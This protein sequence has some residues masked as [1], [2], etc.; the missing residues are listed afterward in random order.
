STSSPRMR[1]F[2]TRAQVSQSKSSGLLLRAG[3][4]EGF[5]GSG[6]EATASAFRAA[7]STAYASRTRASSSFRLATCLSA[8]AR[9]SSVVRLKVGLAD[10]AAGGRVDPTLSI[11]PPPLSRCVRRLTYRHVHKLAPRSSRGKNRIY[12]MN[13]AT[14]PDLSRNMRGL[15]DEDGRSKR[16]RPPRETVTP[17]DLMVYFM[18]GVRPRCPW[19]F[20]G[21]WSSP[22]GSRSGR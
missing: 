16:W 13:G 11:A 8:S 15:T 6:V 19:T 10:L 12:Q 7:S 20:W 4:A 18:K 21:K 1:A 2:L 22:L 9:R 17:L 14:Y 3:S 5:V